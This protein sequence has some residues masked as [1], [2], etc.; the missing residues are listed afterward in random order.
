MG[1]GRGGGVPVNL[2]ER[3]DGSEAG[4]VGDSRAGPVPERA[5][6][7]LSAP[8]TL[9]RGPDCDATVCIAVT[10]PPAVENWKSVPGEVVECTE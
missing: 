5:G 3:G 4:R 2:L 8:L 7:A 1:D 9:T 10:I 6:R